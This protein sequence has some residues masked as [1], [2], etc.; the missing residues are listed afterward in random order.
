ML[1]SLPE[2]WG[3]DFPSV[4]AAGAHFYPAEAAPEVPLSP[5]VNQELRVWNLGGGA[6]R[7]AVGEIYSRDFLLH[8]GS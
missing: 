7:G 2:A 5:S 6:G 8:I 3:E 1:G 4:G